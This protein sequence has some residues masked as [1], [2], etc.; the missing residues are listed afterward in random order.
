LTFDPE[1]SEGLRGVIRR[2]DDRYAIGQV[3]NN[4]IITTHDLLGEA[5][6]VVRPAAGLPERPRT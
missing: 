4:I 3:Q 1:R 2:P 6:A 5:I